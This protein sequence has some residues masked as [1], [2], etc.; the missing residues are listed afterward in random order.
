MSDLSP[1][2]FTSTLSY[3]AYLIISTIAY[4]TSITNAEMMAHMPNVGGPV[5]FICPSSADRCICVYRRLP[6]CHHPPHI[7]RC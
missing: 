4:A 2:S 6:S 1:R 3:Q 5:S 7:T